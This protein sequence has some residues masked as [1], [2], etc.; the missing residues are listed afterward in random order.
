MQ[1]GHQNALHLKTHAGVWLRL[2]HSELDYI[3]YTIQTLKEFLTQLPLFLREFMFE[4]L[5]TLSQ[6]LLTVP[7]KI[8]S[9]PLYVTEI[10]V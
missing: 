8:L 6:I 3:G 7:W 9:F 1:T 4:F 2:Q 10:G 5:S